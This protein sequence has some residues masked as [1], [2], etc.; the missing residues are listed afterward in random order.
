MYLCV[1]RDVF[2]TCFLA[3]TLLFLSHSPFFLAWLFIP[4]LL[5]LS[6]DLTSYVLFLLSPSLMS[7]LPPIASHRVPSSYI[8]LPACIPS[9]SSL[10]SV[11]PLSLKYLSLSK[12][13]PRRCIH[14]YPFL[15]SPFFST[16]LSPPW[17]SYR[18]LDLPIYFLWSSLSL[19]FDL[20]LYPLV[21]FLSYFLVAYL[22][23][24]Y[25]LS[26]FVFLPSFF[27]P[28]ILPPGLA[29]SSLSY[30]PSLYL[31]L[32]PLCS[33]LFTTYLSF[34]LLPSYP[35]T[36]SI[37]LRL[38]YPFCIISR[39][40][41]DRPTNFYFFNPSHLTFKHAFSLIMSSTSSFFILLVG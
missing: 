30:L 4:G 23:P 11:S 36:C 6:P 2:Y 28:S 33:L 20:L 8:T 26:S 27:I 24:L 1:C 14:A 41:P 32:P 31:I 35:S 3:F 25:V 16:C 21:I 22:V 12:P 34:H 38:S 40:P 19:P 17:L 15:F 29:S 18:P 13:L 9:H 5:S 39:L 10:C 37:I 7:Y